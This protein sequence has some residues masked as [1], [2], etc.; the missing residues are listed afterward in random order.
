M[1]KTSLKNAK[2]TYTQKNCYFQKIDFT[3][4]YIFF[5]E[6]VKINSLTKTEAMKFIGH[7]KIQH[8]LSNSI[9][10]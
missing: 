8:P 1:L 6:V 5:Q 7:R 9:A 2:L 3:F 10:V 4:D